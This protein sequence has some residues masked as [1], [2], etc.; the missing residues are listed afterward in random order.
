MNFNEKL[1]KYAE[2]IVKVGANI[3]QGQLMVIRATTDARDFVYALS[4][5]AYK[6]GAGDVQVMWRDEVLTR[7]KFTY[8]SVE[9]VS[10][11]KQWAVDQY[12][13]YV[14]DNAVFVSVIGSNPNNLE[15]LDAEKIKAGTIATS[16]AMSSFRTALMSNQNSWVVVG[17]STPSWAK[18]VFPELDEKEGV[19][20]LWELIFYTSRINEGDCVKGWEDH[21]ATLTEKADYLNKMKFKFLKYTSEKGTNLTIELPKGHLW[22]AGAS[23]NGNGVP[24]TANMPTEEV[25][26]LPHKDGVNGV[27]YSTKPLNY[28]GNLID[29]FMLEFK[30]GKVINYTAEKGFDSLKSLLES[31]EGSVALGEVALVPHDSPISNTNTMFCE[32]LYDENA[33][34][35]LALGRAYPTCLENSENMSEEELLNAGVNFSLVH[36]DF[37]VGDATLNIL[38]ITEDGKEIPVF[39]KGNWA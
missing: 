21:I 5:E 17:A 39:V 4:E 33:S 13:D 34:C 37:M 18:A 32:T 12:D 7:Q 31:D 1:Q 22:V 20:K 28:G 23:L 8:A 14:K 36:E 11:V 19:A 6:A 29:E 3:Q 9:T 2:T 30:D 24:F 27:V 16:K 38:G 10:T 26:T 35:H 15:G 25:F